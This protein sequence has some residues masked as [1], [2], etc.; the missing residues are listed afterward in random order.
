MTLWEL[1]L[2]SA[3]PITE[4]RITI[5]LG[6]IAYDFNPLWI[7]FVCFIGC[8]IPV[9]FILIFFERFYELISKIKGIRVLVEL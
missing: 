4:Q 1:F 9:P 5:P 8:L 6:I 3:V 2:L 7:T